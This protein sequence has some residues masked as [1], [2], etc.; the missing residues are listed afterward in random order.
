MICRYCGATVPDGSVYC[1]MCGQRIARKKR[2][3]KPEGVVKQLK[4]WR[5]PSGNWRIQVEV[6]GQ[7]KSKTFPAAEDA[8]AWAQAVRAGL[9]KAKDS[10]GTIVK[11]YFTVK[12]TA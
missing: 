11:K 6:D 1:N 4:P 7:R 9:I 5:L 12:A 10:S 3:K 8:A 2:E